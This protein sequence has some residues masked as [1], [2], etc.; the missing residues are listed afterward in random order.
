M[1]EEGG[2]SEACTFFFGFNF[3]ICPI[4]TS[5]ASC[6][7][8]IIRLLFLDPVRVLKLHN[9]IDGIVDLETL[10]VRDFLHTLT[11][12]L[13]ITR[14][15]A[16]DVVIVAFLCQVKIAHFRLDVVHHLEE[17]DVVLVT[18]VVGVYVLHFIQVQDG[19]FNRS[20]DLF[21]L[22]DR[23]TPSCLFL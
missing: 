6:V 12:E 18:A 14:H 7:V 17:P 19:I 4:G 13:S 11:V 1:L 21:S 3:F 2:L 16:L 5:I 20:N 22:G 9:L 10:L 23:C 8:L 15:I